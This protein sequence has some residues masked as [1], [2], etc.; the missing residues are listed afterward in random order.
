MT[1]STEKRPFG[2]GEGFWNLPNSLTVLR[3][4][5]V[6]VMVV[7][8]WDEPTLTETAIGFVVFVGAILAIFFLFTASA[9]TATVSIMHRAQAAPRIVDKEFHI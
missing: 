7:L 6:P 9:P 8:L 3:I 1:G 5:L 4:A 2:R